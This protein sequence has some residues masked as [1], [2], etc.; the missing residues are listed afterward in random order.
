M[1]IFL[2]VVYY[3]LGIV[4]YTVTLYVTYKKEKNANNGHS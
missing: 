1:E 2:R 3:T 4:M